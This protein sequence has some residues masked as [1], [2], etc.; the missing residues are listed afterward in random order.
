MPCRSC[1]YHQPRKKQ[2]ECQ[3]QLCVMQVLSVV[4][5]QVLEIQMAVKAKV[6]S[7]IFEGS[8]LPLR[9]SCNVFITMNPGY[10]GRSELP[11]N[12]KALFRTVAMMVPDYAMIA[13]IMLYSSGYQQV[14]LSA[15]LCPSV[16]LSVCFYACLSCSLIVFSSMS[17]SAR[18]RCS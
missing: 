12:L 11:D 4:A 15:C 8:E 6:K 14:C 16:C 7:F 3:R 10:A 5:Q 13:E 17:F 1:C 9:P 2:E 18:Q